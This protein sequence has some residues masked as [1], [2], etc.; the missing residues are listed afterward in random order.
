MIALDALEL[1]VGDLR[2]ASRALSSML[3]LTPREVA[4]ASR[5]GEN[6]T[7]L[8]AGTVAF[9]LRQSSDSGTRVARHVARHGD[10]IADI[11]LICPDADALVRRARDYG[12]KVREEARSVQIDLLGEGSILHSLRHE[13]IF[14]APTRPPYSDL[15]LRS[16]DHVTYCL[17]R[18]TLDPVARVYREVFGLEE[19]QVEDIRSE[20][21]AGPKIN[22]NGMRSIV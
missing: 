18:G 3:E 19:V 8:G 2:E 7:A 1:W 4:A 15:Y 14:A 20:N 5:P 9:V 6:M 13:S 16:V 12:V 17:P 11:D 22:A 21:S 10:S